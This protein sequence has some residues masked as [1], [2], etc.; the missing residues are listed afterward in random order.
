MVFTA[1]WCLNCKA[2]EQS[3]WKDPEVA[4]AIDRADAIPMKVDLTAGNPEGRARLKAAGS[5]TIPLLV[6]YGR[7]GEPLFRS[8]FYTA[9]QV[10]EAVRAAADRLSAEFG[11]RGD[12]PVRAAE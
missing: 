10:E 4:R 1:E 9:A 2:L 5:L 7:K 3:V 6:V 11:Y 12:A 8:D